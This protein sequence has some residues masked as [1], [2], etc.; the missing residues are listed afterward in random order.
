MH[1]VYL[2]HC[3]TT[4]Q[5]PKVTEAMMP[6]FSEMCGNPSSLHHFGNEA[7]AAVE[8]ARKTIAHSIHARENEIYFVSSGTEADNLA[9]KGIAYVNRKNGNHI[10]TSRAEHSAVL[11]SCRALENEGFEVTY[12]DVDKNAQVNPDDIR[13][14]ISKDTILV[15]I[16]H[17]NNEVGTVNNIQQIG[18]IARN[19]GCY[20][21]T[22]AVQSFGKA[23]IDV[24]KSQIDLLSISGHKI[25]GPKGVGA[26]YI[27]QGVQ[28]AKLMHGGRHERNKRAGS[29]NVPG[30]VGLGK[31]ATLCMENHAEESQRIGELRDYFQDELITRFSGIHINGHP[32]QRLYHHLSVSFEGCEADA[33]LL[34]L[35]MEGIAASAGAA[36][37]SG[38]LQPSHVLKAMRLTNQLVYSTL[39]FSLGR[40]NTREE[41][42]FVLEKL[43]KIVPRLRQ[44]SHFST[45]RKSA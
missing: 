41:I 27:R 26:L 8:R 35:D 1:S 19:G 6:Y 20:F 23:P 11:E 14:A 25:H 4:P 5:D 30:I 2:D 16:M 15:S 18:K 17:A 9:L 33:L 31:A 36:C 12:L 13:Q 3:A 39:R 43:D 37:S 22:D 32:E 40:W 34:S 38:S 45:G 7:R 24:E 29:E 42:D 28:L 21:H 10:I 44:I